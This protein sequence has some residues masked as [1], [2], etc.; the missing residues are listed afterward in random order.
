MAHIL[1][2][3]LPVVPWMADHTLRLPGTVPVSLADWL[4]RDE[5]FARQ[6]A[7]RDW[8][9]AE[10]PAEVHALAPSARPAAEELLA[11]VLAHLEG[12][13]GYAREGS[14]IRRP[15]GVLVP[16]AGPP[17]LVAGR[18]VQEDL[19]L[20]DKPDGAAEH[21]LTGAILCFPSNWTLSQKFGMPLTRIHLPVDAYDETVARRVQ[22]LFDAIRPEAPIMRANLI[23]YAHADL[24]SPRPEFSRHSPAPGEIAFVRV[25]RQTLLRLPETRTVVFSVHVYQLPLDRL[26]AAEAER[27]RAVRPGWFAA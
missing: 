10:R 27:L 24:H 26:P 2:D 13:P 3:R 20:L 15:D 14:A 25:E 16:L 23:P 12:V 5:V 19:V 6:M 1:Q 4:Q 21:L 9:I 22:R 11:L 18:L 7:L 17:L 8:L